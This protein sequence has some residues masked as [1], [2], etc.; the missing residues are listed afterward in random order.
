VREI[1]EGGELNPA[2]GVR[3]RCKKNFPSVLFC[4]GKRSREDCNHGNEVGTVHSG[5]DGEG[6]VP[7]RKPKQYDRRG[8]CEKDFVSTGGHW[9]GDMGKG[10]SCSG[11]RE[12]VC[13]FI[14]GKSSVTGDP[15]KA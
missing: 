6:P 4:I 11:F 13:Q 2:K 3:M 9:A 7:L 5:R 14:T 1:P 15:L 10:E 12:R 8:S